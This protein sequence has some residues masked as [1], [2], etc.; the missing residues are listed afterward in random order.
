[1]LEENDDQIQKAEHRRERPA[2]GGDAQGFYGKRRKAVHP[3]GKELDQRVAAL[4]L[5]AGAVRDRHGADASGCAEDE[6]LHIGVA[7]FIDEH[8]VHDET[9]HGKIAR[10][11][12]LPG[13]SEHDLGHAVVDDRAD[14]APGGVLL[15]G[16]FGVDHVVALFE[17][18]DELPHLVTGGL[19]V[20]VEAHHD[21]PR[22]VAKPRHD[23]RVLAEIFCKVDG[24]DALVVLRHVTQ[25]FKGIVR[26]AVVD[27]H[28]FRLIVRHLCHRAFQLLHDAAD[29]V[30]GAVAGDHK[31]YK[32]HL[33]VPPPQ[34]AP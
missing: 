29:R 16:V 22:A 14:V 28:E 30:G 4:A 19:A 1:M 23:G 27:Q 33:I 24:S 34:A 2:V 5:L 12:E 8:F 11:G 15:V 26:G 20:V 31:G 32:L 18:F 25:D 7:V 21:L 6:P 13:F 17:L 9:L 10:D 3:Q